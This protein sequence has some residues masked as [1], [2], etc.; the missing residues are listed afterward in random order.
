MPTSVVAMKE[1]LERA[2]VRFSGEGEPEGV[3]RVLP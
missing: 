3:H 1:A 2:G